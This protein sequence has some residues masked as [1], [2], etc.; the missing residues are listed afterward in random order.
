M[1]E[2]YVRLRTVTVDVETSFNLAWVHMYTNTLR[3]TVM[4]TAGPQVYVKSM[5][6]IL[7]L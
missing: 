7:M 1:R 2:A 6:C 3:N 4:V 5:L